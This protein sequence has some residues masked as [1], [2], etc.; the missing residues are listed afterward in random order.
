MQELDLHAGS[1]YMK[2]NPAIMRTQLH[3]APNR[4]IMNNYQVSV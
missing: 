1:D 2:Q 3:T 4:E